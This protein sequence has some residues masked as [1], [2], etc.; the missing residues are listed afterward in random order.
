MQTSIA[1]PYVAHQQQMAALLLQRQ[2]MIMSAATTSGMKIFGNQPLQDMSSL[3]DN[4]SAGSNRVPEPAKVMN[5][6]EPQ[7]SGQHYSEVRHLDAH[8]FLFC[9]ILEN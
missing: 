6:S 7:F 5:N 2:S 3:H 9:C 8:R 4:L 1:S